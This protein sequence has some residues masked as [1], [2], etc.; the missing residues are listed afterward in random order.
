MTVRIRPATEAD[1]AVAGEICVA[2][3]RADGQLPPALPPGDDFPN[4]HDYSI[5]L[6][7]V[8]SRAEHGEV[9]VAV[10]PTD[11][12]I[13]GC[14]TFMTPGSLYAELSKA[15]EAEFRMLAVAPAAQGRGVGAALVSACLERANDLG[16]DAVVI[17]V[18][19]FN[20]AAKRLYASFGFAAVPDRDW[21]PVP[22]VSLEALRL[23]LPIAS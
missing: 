8:A 9:L 5:T 16:Y 15:D 3:Y 12:A 17:C 18:R 7:D 10:E 20:V 22:G 14:V 23:E 4:G 13:L 2:A 19:D 1:Y 6:A 21:S 11:G